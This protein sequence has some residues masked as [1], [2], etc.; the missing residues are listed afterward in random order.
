MK[1]W[2]GGTLGHFPTTVA[3]SL[4]VAMKCTVYPNRVPGSIRDDGYPEQW[5][6]SFLDGEGA[7]RCTTTVD[8]ATLYVEAFELEDKRSVDA[9][10]QW[11]RAPAEPLK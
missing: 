4:E 3:R 7:L 9:F 1:F 8:G 10:E 2:V 11:E 6:C 5:V